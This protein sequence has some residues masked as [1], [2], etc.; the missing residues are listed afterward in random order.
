MTAIAEILT[1]A[2]QHQ[3][4]L[5]IHGDKLKIKSL[6]G[7]VPAEFVEKA[8]THKPEIMQVLQER[9]NPE[10]AADGYVWCLDCTH[11]D[12]TNCTHKDNPYIEQEPKCPRY[13]KWYRAK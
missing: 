4:Q 2:E 11:W 6:N 1:Y 7:E 9:W 3:I 5:S 10:L 13:C 8:K 12:G